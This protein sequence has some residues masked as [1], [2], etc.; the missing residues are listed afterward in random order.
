MPRGEPSR[1]MPSVGD[2]WLPGSELKIPLAPKKKSKRAWNSLERSGG[3][4]AC[5][6]LLHGRLRFGTW[7]AHHFS[8][9]VTIGRRFCTSR[10]LRAD[11]IHLRIPYVRRW[12]LPATPILSTER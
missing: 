10:D 3:L 8:N 4:T 5:G 12:L 7:P 9:N 2:D 1:L 6:R 11:F